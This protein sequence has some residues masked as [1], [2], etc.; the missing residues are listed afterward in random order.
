M[1]NRLQDLSDQLEVLGKQHEDIM[2]CYN[3]LYEAGCEDAFV[4]ATPAVL[5]KI[6]ELREQQSSIMLEVEK[7]IIDGIP[8]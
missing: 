8:K 4:A 1:D 5:K 7:L 3:G 6:S 2:D